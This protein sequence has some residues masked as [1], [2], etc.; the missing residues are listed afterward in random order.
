MDMKR[1][2]AITCLIWITLSTFA[3]VDTRPAVSSSLTGDRFE[4]I[5]SPIILRQ[6]F[7]LD[8][9]TGDV[10]VISD[11]GDDEIQWK[12]IDNPL[13]EFY[14]KLDDKKSIS[15]QLFISGATVRY[16]FLM[17]IKNGMTYILSKG[18]D[19]GK[20]FFSR[21]SNSAVLEENENQ[22]GEKK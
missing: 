6:V 15:Y 17:N 4:I 16:C 9:F 22:E 18:T 14:G 5:Q 3:Q 7:R 21:I 2:L 10:Y 11:T 20:L 8:K 12:K 19:T 1:I 13:L